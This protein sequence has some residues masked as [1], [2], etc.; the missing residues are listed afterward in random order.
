M[1]NVVFVMSGYQNPERSTL[2]DKLTEMGAQYKSDW[3]PGCTHLIVLDRQH[4]TEPGVASDN[5]EK[6][7]NNSKKDNSKPS[8]EKDKARTI[9]Q[10]EKNYEKDEYERNDQPE[11]NKDSSA[12]NGHKDSSDDEVYEDDTD[13]D[14][15]LNDNPALQFVKAQWIWQCCDKKKLAPHQPYLIVPNE[16]LYTA[17]FVC[18]CKYSLGFP[19]HWVPSAADD[20]EYAHTLYI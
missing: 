1:D 10:S 12:T 18:I 13:I 14:D 5:E 8:S 20:A 4:K 19:S 17:I 6:V 3:S 9:K 11:N 2:R 7:S 15:A 16:P